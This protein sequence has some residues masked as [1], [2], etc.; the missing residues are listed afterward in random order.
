MSK[1][2][3]DLKKLLSLPTVLSPSVSC[4]GCC[5]AFF[6]NVTGR[7][8]VYVA[9]LPDGEPVRVTHGE[10]PRSVRT[11]IVWNRA[12]TNIVFGKDVDGNEKYSLWSL[13]LASGTHRRLTDAPDAREVAL[14]FSPDGR[15]LSFLSTRNGQQNLYKLDLESLDVV[16]LTDFSTPVH[17]SGM[18][19]PDGQSILLS[20]N[21]SADLRN[22]DVYL[23][24]ANGGGAHRVFRGKE[25]S[26]DSPIAWLP[27][28]DRIVVVSDALGSDRPV[29]VD[30]RTGDARWLGADDVEE[31]PTDVSE[32]GRYLLSIQN[33][34]ASMTPIVTEIETGAVRPLIE[35]FGFTYW[36][37]FALGGTAA[38]IDRTTPTR[39]S[40]LFVFPVDDREPRSLTP[41]DYGTID[42]SEFVAP[43]RVRYA[44]SD[45]VTVPAILYEPT[46]IGDRCP[47][48]VVHL[49]GGPW[50]QCVF[51]FYDLVQYLVSRGF[52]ILQPDF[53][54]STGYG[55]AYMDLN[56]MDWGGGDLQDVIAGVDFLIREGKADPQRIAAYGGSYGGYLTYIALTKAPDLWKAGVAW[57]G[58]TDLLAMHDESPPNMQYILRLMMGDPEE[59]EELWRDR[60]AIYFAENLKAKLLMIHG[61]N[62]ARCPVTQAHAFRDRLLEL[63]Y[64][65][66][67]D[68]EYVELG[69]VGHGSS[70]I[71][72]KIETYEAI[73]RY[74]EAN[75]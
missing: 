68:F 2:N 61:V 30:K 46:H 7:M 10:L 59:N 21:Q 20:N 19:S 29:I 58:I 13:E 67:T 70:D 9:D 8:E 37:E 25:G 51:A 50:G 72:D 23:V 27:D 60:S 69:E 31:R 53:R 62:D 57:I 49:H 71:G 47:P 39:K 73:T 24:G 28:G 75:V 34:D 42:P 22:Q 48:A 43:R 44:S 45:G 32:D 54:G 38:V 41:I 11:S 64:E 17:Q 3:I 26:M 15:W 52:A 74:L 56:Y 18:W 63:G 40:E 35:V 55:R 65:E 66:G 33:C 36:A 4:D 14:E 12:G 5:V 6:W 1:S 16:Q